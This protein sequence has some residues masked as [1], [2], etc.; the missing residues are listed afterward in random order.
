MVTRGYDHVGVIY[1]NVGT[2]EFRF[3][4]ASP[5][6]KRLDYVKL[7]HETDGV[8]LAQVMEVTRETS[9]S[10]DDAALSATSGD[11]KMEDRLTA[12]ARVVGYRD[13]RG[14]LQVPRTP[15]RAG[16][17][18]Y[19][20]D[21]ALI[22]GVFGL[23][24]KDGAYLGH[25]KGYDL[26]VHLD[27]NTLVQK[28]VS[29]LAKTGGGKSYAVGVLMEELIKKGVPIV[30]IDPHGEHASLARPNHERNDFPI[31]R[32][33]GVAP[34]G[35][36]EHIIEYSPDTKT[37]T[38]AQ[39]LTLDGRNLTAQE[40][41]DILGNKL[42]A[43]QMGLLHAAARELA[44][45]GKPYG[46]QDILDRVK[47]GQANTKWNLVSLLEFLLGLGIFADEGTPVASLVKRDKVSIINL[48]GVA[49]EIQEVIVASLA[50][51][52]FEARKTGK[53]APFMLVVEEAHNFCPERGLSHALSGDVLRTVASE[54]R[55]FGMGLLI[56]SQRP[57]KVDKNVLSQ[58]NT[59]LI[60]KVTN[61]NDLKAI[62]HSVE[63]L[64][65]DMESEIQRL[66]VGVA[67]VS[68]P[69]ISMPIL[70]EVRPRETAH[71]G[72][73]VDVMEAVGESE[74]FLTKKNTE[75]TGETEDAE[76]DEK[77]DET[78]HAAPPPPGRAERIAHEPTPPAQAMLNAVPPP[79]RHIERAVPLPPWIG[80]IEEDV[81]RVERA[82]WR[83]WNA[84]ALLRLEKDLAGFGSRLAGLS[85][86]HRDATRE[87]HDRLDKLAREVGVARD[88]AQRKKRGFGSLFGRKAK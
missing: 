50:K 61:P 22:A 40:L 29:I 46:I 57:A 48:R 54:G 36:A 4:V 30:I 13:A 78:P 71:G 45:S 80:P 11:K 67:I 21:D 72:Q 73:S 64:N 38:D 17:L 7:E 33:F 5:E 12:H 69:R 52:L 35:Y 58:C 1:G 41:A 19:A 74:T 60:L 53:I 34:H 85:H 79:P 63:G 32:K 77:E 26:P 70:V 49:P 28:H 44:E 76:D 43:A 18:L 2:T 39:P 55:K 31:M 16:A 66:P 27:I 15:F 84:E 42:S 68:H 83:T 82:P 87:L 65:A 86:D 23:R 3:A 51:K 75:E 59:Q 47:A 20:A 8:V 37:N 88:E 56:V 25:I 24:D 62:T 14:I 9:L 81:A 10:F 6:L